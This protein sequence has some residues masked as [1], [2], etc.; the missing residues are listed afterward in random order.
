M[1]VPSSIGTFYILVVENVWR[2]NLPIVSVAELM[3]RMSQWLL[4]NAK[5]EHFQSSISFR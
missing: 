1:Y 3:E 5:I 4:I 2:A